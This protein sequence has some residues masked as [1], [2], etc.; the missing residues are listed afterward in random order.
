M[1]EPKD[2]LK[3]MIRFQKKS[4]ETSFFMAG[5]KK[6]GNDAARTTDNKPFDATRDMYSRYLAD[7]I[8]DSATDVSDFE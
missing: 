4:F 1:I 6:T 2:F 8:N 7:H 3:D 5:P